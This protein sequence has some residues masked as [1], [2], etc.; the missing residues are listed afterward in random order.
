[1]CLY[2]EG[3]TVK[4]FF[5][6]ISWNT[7]LTSI[8][9]CTFRYQENCPLEN[10]PPENYPHQK[11]SPYESSP[12]ENC[13]PEYLP[14]E[15][16]PP[17]KITPNE[18]L[19]PLI[20]HTNEWKNKITKFFA[21][22]KPVQYNILIKITSVLFDTQMISQKILRLDTFLTEWKKSKNRTKA[23]I[24]KWHLLS[25]CT[26]QGELIRQSNYKI[27]QIC[28]T[29]TV[30]TVYECGCVLAAHVSIMYTLQICLIRT[31]LK[32]LPSYREL[33]EKTLNE[34]TRWNK[35]FFQVGLWE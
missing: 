19:S 27:W 12:C 23:R 5:P 22:K 1:M 32:A 10:C 3:Y 6:S 2:R 7:N 30:T 24:T 4:F 14:R 20:N 18:I 26:S 28:K 29:T 13:P 31:N 16:C 34:K 25:S 35:P 11:I 9:Q 21:L 8:S 17:G 15:N 33:T